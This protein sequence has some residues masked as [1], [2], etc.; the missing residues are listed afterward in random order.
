M[1]RSIRVAG[2]F[3]DGAI[4]CGGQ[5]HHC[6]QAWRY[7]MSPRAA[8]RDAM[9]TT[10]SPPPPSA[11]TC[12]RLPSDCQNLP[13]CAMTCQRLPLRREVWPGQCLGWK[14]IG[15]GTRRSMSRLGLMLTSTSRR[16]CS[17]VA[18]VPSC[19]NQV[20]TPS[21]PVTDC[22]IAQA[23]CACGCVVLPTR[24]SR[25]RVERTILCDPRPAPRAGSK[26]LPV[27]IC[28]HRKTRTKS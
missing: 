2:F 17:F 10:S 14:L 19:G 12:Q 27:P 1:R 8:F 11:K 6:G 24:P 21:R 20:R 18:S 28:R 9:A 22:H 25:G 4:M 16:R 5:R 3:V 15:L 26:P 7:R 23:A 13:P